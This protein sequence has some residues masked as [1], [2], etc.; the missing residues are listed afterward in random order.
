MTFDECMHVG[1][2]SGCRCWNMH[3]TS[4]WLQSAADGRSVPRYN[5]SILCCSLASL[6]LELAEV[7]SV[8]V[9]QHTLSCC[10]WQLW[11][12]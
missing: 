3:S 9:T 5:V 11:L 2:C 10:L 12:S 8:S 4:A 1:L 7:W 6:L